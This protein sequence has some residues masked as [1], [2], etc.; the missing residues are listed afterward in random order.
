MGLCTTAFLQGCQGPFCLLVQTRPAASR[1]LY[2][3]SGA[4]NADPAWFIGRAAATLGITQEL[5]S[6]TPGY[7]PFASSQRTLRATRRSLWFSPGWTLRTFLVCKKPQQ[8]KNQAQRESAESFSG[9]WAPW[10][11]QPSVNCSRPLSDAHARDPS[12]RAQKSI[13]NSKWI[14]KGLPT[15]ISLV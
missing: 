6:S 10:R 15:K 1:L 14:T 13:I 12:A 3:G 9:C 5:R 2:G 4:V 8:S 11:T 7:G